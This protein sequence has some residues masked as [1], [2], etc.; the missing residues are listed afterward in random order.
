[1]TIPPHGECADL[2]TEQMAAMGVEVTVHDEQAGADEPYRCP[3]GRYFWVVPTPAQ[4]ARWS[5]E[6]LP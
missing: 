5:V 4:V 1:M 3:H 6:D 2:L